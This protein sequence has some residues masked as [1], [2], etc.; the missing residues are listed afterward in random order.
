MQCDLQIPPLF[1]FNILKS[2]NIFTYRSCFF[3]ALIWYILP[4]SIHSLFIIFEVKMKPISRK[5]PGW[6]HIPLFVFMA[7]S[8]VQTALGFEDLFGKGFAWAF[9]IAI[10][11][12]MYGFTI[13]IGQRRINR[14]PVAGFL[15][16][17]FFFS[18]FSFAGNFNAI[19]TSYQKEQLFRDELL[20]HKQQLNDVVSATNKALN[21]FSPE[22][23]EKR[24]RVEA[25]TEQLVS[26]ITDPNRPGL[27]KRALELISEIEGVLGEKLTEFG[28]RGGDWKSIAER[29]RENIDQIARRK[30][31]TKDYEKIEE[32]RENT[33]KKAKEI[34]TLIDSVLQDTFSVKEYGFETNL[35]AVNTINEIGSNT[36]EFINDSAVFKFNKV[37]FESQ[38]IG[39]IA[40]SFKS[41]FV[42]H[43]LVAL[44]FVILCLFID[45]AVVLSL[46]VF[47]GRNEKEP[48][49]VINSGRAM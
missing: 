18:L 47:F 14:L 33:Q 31:S 27:G 19:Y 22:I 11:M 38:E 42:D 36:Q 32:I 49:Q 46:L 4:S 34:N 44:L 12:L 41:A 9:S 16:A 10:T 2:L 1:L 40:F 24:N 39:K 26:Q 3:F 30:L 7:I 6:V 21:N 20:K 28:T 45:W 48:V 43:T 35:K 29:Y 37:A 5:L 25:L 15:I 8:L 13:F 23:T 17:Y